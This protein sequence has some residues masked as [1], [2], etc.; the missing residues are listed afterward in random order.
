MDELTKSEEQYQRNI[1]SHT[2]TID[3]L[4]GFYEEKLQR[5]EKN[6]QRILNETIDQ[7][8]VGKIHHQ[9]NKD[10]ILLQSITHGV[11]QQLE[12]SLNNAKSIALSTVINL[13]SYIRI[14]LAST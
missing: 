4:L 7:T 14:S 6:Y 9:Q 11:Q 2:E 13:A 8:D 1:R 10:Q 3:R 5:E 12:E